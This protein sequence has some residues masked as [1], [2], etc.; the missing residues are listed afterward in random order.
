VLNAPLK[1]TDPTGHVPT[2]CGNP[3]GQG[4]GAGCNATGEPD[5]EES[6]YPDDPD[7]NWVVTIGTAGANCP[8][9]SYTAC[10]YARLR[11]E[12]EDTMMVDPSEFSELMIAVFFDVRNRERNALERLAYDTLFWDGGSEPGQVCFGADC[13]ERYEVNYFAQGMWSAAEGEDEELSLYL[14][15]GAWKAGNYVL[16]VLDATLTGNP[17]RND[18]YPS[19]E[20]SAGTV[21]WYRVGYRNYSVFDAHHNELLTRYPGR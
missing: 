16:G 4:Y 10:H 19:P 20:P 2:P 14:V 5:V 15:V 17:E 6:D 8:Y 3:D 13:Y 11:F 1:H 21:F 12:I 18:K 9:A 7:P